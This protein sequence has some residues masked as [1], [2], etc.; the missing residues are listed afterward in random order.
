MTRQTKTPRQRAEEALAAA[1]R[2]VKR[3]ATK[4]NALHRDI[5]AIDHDLAAAVVRLDYLATNP[6][7]QHN[8]SSTNTG[9][10]A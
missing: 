2:T 6:D 3:L 4:R 5:E 10:P 7:L 1:D 8:P 9:D